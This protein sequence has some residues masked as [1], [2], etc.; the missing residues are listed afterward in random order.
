M[1]NGYGECKVTLGL[2]IVEGT[3]GSNYVLLKSR[4]WEGNC[5]DYVKCE[6]NASYLKIVIESVMLLT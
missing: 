3:T 1:K 5:G 4:F 6:F 2:V